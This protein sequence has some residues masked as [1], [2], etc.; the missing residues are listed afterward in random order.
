MRKGTKSFYDWCIENSHEDWLDLWD[1]ELNGCS[2]KDIS[3]GNH[4]KYYFK[5]PKG[6]HKSELKTINSLT[7]CKIKLKCNQCNSF[8]QWCLNNDRKGWLELWDYELNKC[9]PFNVLCGTQKKYY[10]K[11]PKKLHNSELKHINSFVSSEVVLKCNQC[12]SFGQWCIE[13]NHEDWLELW[14]YELN[15]YSPFEVIKSSNKKYWFKCPRGIHES[16]LKNINSFIYEKTVLKCNY[17]NSFGQYLIDEFGENALELYWDYKLNKVNPFKIAK[18]S[19][20][21]IWIKCQEKEYHNSYKTKAS[22]FA[23][24]YRCPNCCNFHGKVHPKDSFAQYHID[25]TDK[26]FIEKYWSDKNTID[27]FSIAPYS[28]TQIWIKCQNDEEHEDY[29]IKSYY[30]TYGGRCNRCNESS[31]GER[32]ISIWLD[33][34][35][36]KYKRE[37]IFEDL[38]G[39]GNNYLRYDFYLPEHNLLIEYQ[40]VQHYQPIDFKGEGKEKAKSRFKTQQE[41][42]KRKRE[43]AELHNIKLLE[44]PYW[45]FDDIKAILN[46]NI[47]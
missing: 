24:G 20:T 19:N 29:E 30:F 6:I 28:E 15:K 26:D 7:S 3:Y 40:G 31:Y 35:N 25:N 27:P 22:G 32:E 37:K 12:N 39:V 47:K 38:L 5:C 43:Y 10:F 41:H 13:N 45:D 14:D 34:K 46:K 4:N 8:G 17:C 2:P 42:D 18:N 21:Q 9:S 11:C 1:Y 33:N 23:K 44:I 36:I 16:E